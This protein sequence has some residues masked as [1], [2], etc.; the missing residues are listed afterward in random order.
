[1]MPVIMFRVGPVNPVENVQRSVCTH[2]EDIISS[3]VFD[4][5][6]A[7]QD[8]QL[9]HNGNAFQKDRKGPQ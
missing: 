1:M 3:Q 9:G 7:L 2:E 4:F 5:A 8:D 6:V